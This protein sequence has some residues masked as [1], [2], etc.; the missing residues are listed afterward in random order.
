MRLVLLG[1]LITGHQGDLSEL[2]LAL[3][4][5]APGLARVDDEIL[6]EPLLVLPPLLLKEDILVCDGLLP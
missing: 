1:K 6:R 2:S 5:L 3:E 4:P